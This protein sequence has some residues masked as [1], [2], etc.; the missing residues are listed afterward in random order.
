MRTSL[1]FIAMVGSLNVPNPAIAQG[2]SWSG[3]VTV[4]TDS[5]HRGLSETAG[6]PSLAI[7]FD[8]AGQRWFAGGRLSNS[9][10]PLPVNPDNDSG[11]SLA[12]YGGY[13]WSISDLWSAKWLLTR[14]EFTGAQHRVDGYNELALNLG[15]DQFNME[16]AI[17]PDAWGGDGL[18]RYATAVSY[19]HLT[20]PTN[21]EV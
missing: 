16:L 12:I 4:A 6:E 13:R 9:R 10:L 18:T 15:N 7:G 2:A 21:R 5:V 11:Q 17:A 14:Y 20:L 19:T 8:R 3:V 1:F